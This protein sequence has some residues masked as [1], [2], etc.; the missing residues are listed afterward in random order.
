MTHYHVYVGTKNNP[1][2]KNIFSFETGQQAVDKVMELIKK[3]GYSVDQFEMGHEE[4]PLG[5]FSVIMVPGVD[6]KIVLHECNCIK[7]FSEFKPLD[8]FKL[9]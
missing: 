8:K 4:G 3:F 2:P 6:C 7:K 9:N 5:R 1:T